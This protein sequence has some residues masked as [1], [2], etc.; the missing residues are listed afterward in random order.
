M[1]KIHCFYFT[2][3]TLPTIVCPQSEVKY[4]DADDKVT[5]ENVTAG[6]ATAA[7]GKR[8][9]TDVISPKTYT[10]SKDHLYEVINLKQEATDNQG[11]TAVCSFQ[12]LIKREYPGPH[13]CLFIPVPHQT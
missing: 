9:V 3:E 6:S 11:L 8:I 2:D 12:Y 7:E 1:T 10:L 13:G 4:V 5:T